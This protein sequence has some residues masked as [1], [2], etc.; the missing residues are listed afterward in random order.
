VDALQR[1]RLQIVP[2]QAVRPHEIAD[3][4]REQRIATRLREEGVLRD[5]VMVGGLPGLDGYILLDG[6]N[7]KRALAE[8]DC[9]WLL[10]QV[11]DYADEHA[12]QLR[13]WCHQVDC[14][15]ATIL[16]HA[17]RVPDVQVMPLT[18]L[19]AADALRNPAT[20]AVVLDRMQQFSI[21]RRTGGAHSRAEQLVQLVSAYEASMTRVDCGPE[22]V[23]ERAQSLIAGCLVAFP[24]FSRSDVVTIALRGALIP[25][26]ITRHVIRCG[27]ALRVNLPLSL[28]SS[29]YD[30]ESANAALQ[31]HLAGLQPRLYLEPTILYDS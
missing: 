29:Q 4:A 9:P 2:G 28:L 5:P 22:D 30:L 14:A 8:M 11:I 6:T 3:P 12:V 16:T 26:G 31:Q 25:A 20:L 1:V 19:A 17:A 23:E 18:A 15:M 21:E 24:G 13:T 10:A 7:R 27:R